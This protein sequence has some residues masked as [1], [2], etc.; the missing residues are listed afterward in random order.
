MSTLRAW[1]PFDSAT[2]KNSCVN[3]RVRTN[4]YFG[5]FVLR[6]SCVSIDGILFVNDGVGLRTIMYINLC[7]IISVCQIQA[8]AMYG[9]FAEYI[10]PLIWDV[11][12]QG[13][14]VVKRENNMFSGWSWILI[15][16]IIKRKNQ[17]QI[18]SFDLSMKT[19]NNMWG[20]FL[21]QISKLWFWNQMPALLLPI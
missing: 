16:F 7:R 19:F 5:V 12:L 17:I 20:M 8:S 14:Q 2:L 13:A 4:M 15:F 1:D 11:S 18:V 6:K 3:D 9:N 10:N 21:K